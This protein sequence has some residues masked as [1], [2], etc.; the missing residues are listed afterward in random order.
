MCGI[1]GWVG[2]HKAE[3]A[4]EQVQKATSLLAHRGPQQEH[5]W[6][7]EQGNVA[8]GHRRLCIIDLSDAAAQ[9]MHLHDRF[10]IV[11]NGEVYNYVEVRNELI[12][13]GHSFHSHSDTEVVLTAYAQW[14]TDCL[15]RFDGMF[16]FT[17]WDEQEQ[18]VFAAR[19]R[20]G[21]KPFF[22]HFDDETLRF[23]SELKAL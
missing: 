7:N 4:L 21:E 22:F 20:F 5:F 16:A 18:T 3:A 8:F 15:Q 17:I 1:A 12:K 6:Q 19:D 14:G 13:L 9:P 23:A 2:Q 11:Y 10:T